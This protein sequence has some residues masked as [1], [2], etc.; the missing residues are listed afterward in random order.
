[1]IPWP[2]GIVELCGEGQWVSEVR[3]EVRM[4]R[5]NPCGRC[6]T[7]PRWSFAI[8]RFRLSK[9]DRRSRSTRVPSEQP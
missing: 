3:L 1:V 8:T 9:N 6:R 7:H 4:E 2:G 5:T